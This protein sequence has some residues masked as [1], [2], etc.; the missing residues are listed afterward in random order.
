[1]IAGF[2]ADRPADEFIAHCAKY[3]RAMQLRLKRFGFVRQAHHPPLE[4]YVLRMPPRSR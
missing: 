4:R 2:I 1:M 3:A